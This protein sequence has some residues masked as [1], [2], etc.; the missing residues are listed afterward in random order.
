VATVMEGIG[1]R[2]LVGMMNIRGSRWLMILLG[3]PVLL[4]REGSPWGDLGFGVWR[5]LGVW[6]QLRVHGLLE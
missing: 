6:R 1:E 5:L 4:G 2:E 3:V